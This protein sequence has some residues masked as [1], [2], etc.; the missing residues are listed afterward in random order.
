MNMVERDQGKRETGGGGT[1]TR[2]QVGFVSRSESRSA[3]D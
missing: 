2:K 3:G 1:A